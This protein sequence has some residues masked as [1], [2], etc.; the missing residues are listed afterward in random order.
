MKRVPHILFFIL[1]MLVFACKK[2]PDPLD[3]PSV[4]PD[5]RLDTLVTFS[6][7]VNG[8]TWQT[9]SVEANNV[10]YSIDTTKANLLVTAKRIANDT[11]TII[12]FSIAQFSDTG[13]YVINPPAISAT[14]YIGTQRHYATSGQIEITS[15]A[16][17]AIIG[18][19]I[20]VADS[21]VVTNGTFNVQQP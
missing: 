15:Y 6:A 14:Y 8:K 2:Q 11:T 21:I 18:T 19:I 4:Q 9:D 16:N 10:A 5:N 1:T 7:T 20:F 17:Y 12:T 3:L 13:I